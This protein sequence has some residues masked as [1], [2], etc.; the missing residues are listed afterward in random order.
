MAPSTSTTAGLDDL[1]VR[2]LRHGDAERP[3]PPV[4]LGDVRPLREVHRLRNMLA[5]LLEQASL[6]RR[7]VPARAGAALGQVSI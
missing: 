6:G 2:S 7:T 4:R 1:V 5:K 3:Q